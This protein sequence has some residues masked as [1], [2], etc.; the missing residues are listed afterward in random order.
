M[1]GYSKW[2]E[3]K[4]LMKM[5]TAGDRGWWERCSEVF[6]RAIIINAF[7]KRKNEEKN[8]RENKKRGSSGGDTGAIEK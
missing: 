3:R 7:I 5:I 6:T 1:A 8:K 2:L 4:E